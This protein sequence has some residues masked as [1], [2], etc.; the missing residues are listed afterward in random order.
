[1]KKLKYKKSEESD[2][3]AEMKAIYLLIKEFYRTQAG[4]SPNGNVFSIGMNQM[5]MFIG[6]EVLDCIDLDADGKLKSSDCD[7][8]FITVN[9]TGKRLPTN[10]ANAM[11]RC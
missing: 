7:R 9:A 5:G 8:L 2:I 10:P 6:S 11:I 4:Y 3:K 1:M